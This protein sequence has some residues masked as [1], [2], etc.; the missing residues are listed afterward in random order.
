MQAPLCCGPGHPVTCSW[1]SCPAPTASHMAASGW[2]AAQEA[3][4]RT[5]PGPATLTSWS[6]ADGRPQ[7]C[8]A[9]SGPTSATACC[10][11][12]L[13]AAAASAS[14]CASPGLL[15]RPRLGSLL[16]LL[17]RAWWLQQ[18]LPQQLG[19]GCWGRV[20]TAAWPG[21]RCTCACSRTLPTWWC[22]T[23]QSQV[24]TYL[25]QSRG[26]WQPSCVTVVLLF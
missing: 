12:R 1:S 8:C 11:S 10:S 16:W 22:L 17:H 14:P 23:Q 21:P 6:H 19:Q 24:R 3:A 9:C 26:G 25:H 7:P 13:S 18:Q 2:A 20:S 15:C 4:G 5:Q